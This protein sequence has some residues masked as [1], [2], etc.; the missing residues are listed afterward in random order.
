[1]EGHLIDI[2]PQQHFAAGD[3]WRYIDP[4]SGVST[5]STV[6]L[7][8]ESLSKTMISFSP[9]RSRGAGM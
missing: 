7:W 9:C 5:N 1:M 6:G 2:F 3:F 4:S 8:K